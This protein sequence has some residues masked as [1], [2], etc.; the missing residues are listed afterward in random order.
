ME[1]PHIAPDGQSARQPR[2]LRALRTKERSGQAILEFAMVSMTFLMLVFGT[3][4]FGRIIYKY[5][6]LQNAVREGARYGKMNPTDNFGV[7]AVVIGHGDGLNI[8][9][10]KI[11]VSCDGG[12]Y[13]GCSNVTVEASM[14]VDI[15]TARLLGLTEELPFWMS[16]SATV[17]AE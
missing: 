6:Q 8:Q 3:V 15:F 17:T 4:D 5:S 7:E 16:S 13:P 10:G 14:Q 11:V 2:F 9:P 12:C 1:T